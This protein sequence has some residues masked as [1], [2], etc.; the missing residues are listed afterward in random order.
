MHMRTKD[1]YK[2]YNLKELNVEEI[3]PYNG[4]L[5]ILI[6]FDVDI[7]YIANGFRPTYDT[8][9]HHRFVFCDIPFEEIIKNPQ[10]NDYS[11]IG[12]SIIINGSIEIKDS[13]VEA[14]NND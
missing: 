9:Y 4:S 11:L 8:V 14:I 12:D 13:L 3:A 5:S 6:S 1:F 7:Q 2:S 10:I